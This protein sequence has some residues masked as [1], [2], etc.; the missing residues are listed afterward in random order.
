MPTGNWDTQAH[1]RRCAHCSGGSLGA[2]YAGGDY[3][4]ALQNLRGGEATRLARHVEPFFWSDAEVMHIKLCEGCA[5]EL[6]L[7]AGPGESTL[8][9]SQSG[10]N[11]QAATKRP[12]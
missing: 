1:E 4:R 11:A 9:I 7:D 8:T 6:G 5:A 3:L 2:F 12:S 10:P